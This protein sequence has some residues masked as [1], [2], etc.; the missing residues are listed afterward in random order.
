MASPNLNIAAMQP[1]KPREKWRLTKSV[2]MAM[3]ITFVVTIFVQTVCLTFAFS[4]WASNL[5]TRMV[6][7][8]QKPDLTVQV[9]RLETNVQYLVKGFDEMKEI[10]RERK[11]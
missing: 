4:W 2:P 8:E 9:T 6:A 7:M 1:V 3:I 10:L 11:R 5:S